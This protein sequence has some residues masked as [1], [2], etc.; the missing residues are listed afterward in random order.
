MIEALKGEVKTFLKILKEINKS[1]KG[2]YENNKQVK[3]M[4]QGLNIE[5]G[6]IKK[7]EEM[8]NLGK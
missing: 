3:E 1:L 5:I 6:T 8:E 7:I 2:S 4:F